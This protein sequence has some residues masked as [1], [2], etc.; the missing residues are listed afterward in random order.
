VRGVRPPS[1]LW[2]A[3][4]KERAR[5]VSSPPPWEQVQKH[6]HEAIHSEAMRAAAEVAPEEPEQ[7][8]WC[9]IEIAKRLA[10]YVWRAA[11]DE[12]LL[13]MPWDRVCKEVVQRAMQSCSAACG[14]AVW[15]FY[16]DLPSVICAAVW[17]ILVASGEAELVNHDALLDIIIQEHEDKLDRI[18]LDRAMWQTCS[19]L[20]SDEK[21]QTKMFQA[22]SRSY[23]PALDDALVPL[24]MQEQ[25]HGPLTED[26]ALKHT[27]AFMRKWM[28]DS[29]SRVWGFVERTEME[30]TAES[31]ALLF[32]S[33]IAPFGEEDPFTCVPGALTEEIGRPPSDWAFV[34]QA[35][36][37]LLDSWAQHAGGSSWTKRKRDSADEEDV[38]EETPARGGRRPKRIKP[39]SKAKPRAT[40]PRDAASTASANG[41]LRAKFTGFGRR[42][43]ADAEEFAEG[44]DDEEEGVEES[45][46]LETGGDQPPGHPSCTSEE[47]CIGAP[48][49]QLIQHLLDGRPGDVYCELCWDSFSRRNP[50]L[51]GRVV[52]E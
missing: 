50:S 30:L 29:M 12:G 2:N 46:G 33:L 40:A 21:V 52:E 16:V 41:K 47:E 9:D 27:E 23:W 22:I 45:E 28:S 1:A 31:I 38:E 35:A 43:R 17:E 25:M 19:N 3:P 42:D 18:L 10:K 7:G 49:C 15:F 36:Q 51:E 39:T 8:Q 13:Q 6:V 4:W 5:R 48:D 14:E 34:P 24:I 37:D 11:A 20:F 44:G 32:H 26:K